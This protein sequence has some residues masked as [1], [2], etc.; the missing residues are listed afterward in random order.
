MRPMIIFLA[1]VQLGFAIKH[2]KQVR[3]LA[4]G[5]GGSQKQ[6]AIGLKR[7]MEQRQQSLLK[8]APQIDQQ[9]AATEQVKFGKRRVF[10]NVLF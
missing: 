8:V 4:H 9:I 10:G 6:P 2:G 3:Q 7:V 5:F 1:L